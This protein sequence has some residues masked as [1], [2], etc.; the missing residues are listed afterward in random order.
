MAPHHFGRGPLVR[1][2]HEVLRLSGSVRRD[3]PHGRSTTLLV[4]DVG[5][6]VLRRMPPRPDTG[7]VVG[8]REPGTLVQV[9][10]PDVPFTVAPTRPPGGGDPPARAVDG[11]AAVDR[12]ALVEPGDDLFLTTAVHP[13]ETL[14]GLLYTHGIARIDER[15]VHPRPHPAPRTPRPEP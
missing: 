1:E 15:S 10:E 8:W 6:A 4:M 3:G 11:K 12:E 7:S 13:D 5:D 9:Q 14:S 2:V